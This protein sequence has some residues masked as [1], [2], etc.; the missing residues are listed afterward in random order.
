MLKLDPVDSGSEAE[1]RPIHS[2]EN[3]QI[4]PTVH[5]PSI[6][7]NIASRKIKLTKLTVFFL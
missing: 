1:D 5:I 4:K 7:V 6:P 3:S 2:K